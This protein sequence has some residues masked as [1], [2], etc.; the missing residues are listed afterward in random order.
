MN[1]VVKIAIDAMGGDG[2]PKKIVDGIIHHYKNN[3]NTYYQIFGDKE[4][5]L[6]LINDKLPS[7][8]F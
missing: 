7:N 4:K 3:K 8:S 1:N 5:I 6:Y 2:S